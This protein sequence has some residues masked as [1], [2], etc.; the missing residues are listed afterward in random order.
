MAEEIS[1]S[2]PVLVEDRALAALSLRFAATALPLP[3]ALERFLPK[4]REC[5][6]DISTQFVERQPTALRQAPDAAA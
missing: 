3:A 5:A 4:L 1:I 6:A 2:V